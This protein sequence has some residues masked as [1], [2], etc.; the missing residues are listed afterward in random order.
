MLPLVAIA[1][2]TWKSAFRSKMF[3]VLA[4][5]LLAAVAL[6][7][8]VVKGDGTARGFVQVV[9]TYTL[10]LSAALLGFSTLW[11]SCGVMARDIEECQIQMVA[12]KPVGKWQIWAGKWIGLLM[13]NA[14]LLAV[15]GVSIL[16][17]LEW[18]SREL[19][20]QQQKILAEEVLVSR[21][22][23]KPLMPPL[24]DI[25]RRQFE[26]I[27][28]MAKLKGQEAKDAYMSIAEAVYQNAQLIAPNASKGWQ[29]DLGAKATQ[30][31]DQP[32]YIRTRFYSAS[33]NSGSL[34]RCQ[35]QF[36]NSESDVRNDTPSMRLAADSFHEFAIP[37]SLIDSKGRLIV[38]YQNLEP[39]TLLFSLI[40]S[41]EVLYR[42]GNFGFN[43][44]RGLAI[45][46]AW[47]SLLSAIALAAASITSFPV[48]S[49]FTLSL[50][51]VAWSGS[52]MAEAVANETVIAGSAM[53]FTTVRPIVD[54]ILLPL[55]KGLLTVLR[56]LDVAS[57]I[58]SLSG[59]RSISW[60]LVGSAW[61]QIVLLA[62]GLSGLFGIWLL[63]RRELA[64]SQGSS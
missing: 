56:L 45:L 39:V 33:T 42:D 13:L 18:R 49:F 7:P 1:R 30:L 52:S 17:V 54:A 28:E 26:S 64:S 31:R 15:A 57:P 11:L 21:A 38:I 25:A 22:S 62:G 41:V 36:A 44:A 5:A 37:S 14:C 12:V 35:W 16:S 59:G 32:L 2:L 48:A 55:F 9:L 29:F 34:Y 23:F 50:L 53:E 63:S 24:D 60:L 6:L 40:D 3:W 19:T 58:E 47:L 10:S 27:P 20:P 46:L 51:I 61:L 8:A 4:G 43:L